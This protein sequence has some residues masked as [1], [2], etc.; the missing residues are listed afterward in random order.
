MAATS[1]EMTW[2]AGF[3]RRQPHHEKIENVDVKTAVL[4]DE[5]SN[6]IPGV[7]PVR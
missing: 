7:E 5:N 4:R 2:A 3:P 6:R 1:P